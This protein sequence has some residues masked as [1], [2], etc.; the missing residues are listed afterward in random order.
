VG[1]PP[2]T[3]A[4]R[5]EL[6]STKAAAGGLPAEAL[7]LLQPLFDQHAGMRKEY[8]ALHSRFDLESTQRRQLYNRLMEYQGNIRVFCRCRPML[9]RE[10]PR[11]HTTVCTS[12]RCVPTNKRLDPLACP[13]GLQCIVSCA[14]L[15]RLPVSFSTRHTVDLY[16]HTHT[17][18]HH[19]L[20]VPLHTPPI[21]PSLPRRSPCH[22]LSKA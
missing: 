7:R 11:V 5:R 3:Q 17:Q 13:H 6:A 19:T 2:H 18:P 21:P 8:D 20:A 4:L 15:W 9:T 16:T 10:V 12:R 22:K 1:G 14:A